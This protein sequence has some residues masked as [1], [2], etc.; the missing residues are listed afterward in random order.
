MF[1]LSNINMG[2]TTAESVRDNINTDSTTE[3]SL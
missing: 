1:M 2:S 3:K